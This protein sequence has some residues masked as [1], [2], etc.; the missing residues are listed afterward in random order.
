MIEGRGAGRLTT[1]VRLAL[2]VRPAAIA[3][4]PT[5]CVT[6]RTALTDL[7]LIWACSG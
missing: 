5:H 6:R 1:W 4:R 7:K 2:L 3:G